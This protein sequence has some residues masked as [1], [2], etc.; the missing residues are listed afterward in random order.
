MLLSFE[1]ALALHFKT[2]SKI[3]STLTS[4]LNPNKTDEVDVELFICSNKNLICK[5]HFDAVASPQKLKKLTKRNVA[6][7]Q[8][9]TWKVETKDRKEST[10]LATPR[11]LSICCLFSFSSI[12]QIMKMLFRFFEE[13]RRKLKFPI[14]KALNSSHFNRLRKV[15]KS[16][17]VFFSPRL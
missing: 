5:W 3:K 6:I 15:C 8:S 12:F 2:Q 11:I 13:S 16:K 4:T 7:R 10:D 14:A 1:F 17:G 9:V